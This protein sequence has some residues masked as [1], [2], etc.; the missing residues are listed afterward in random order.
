MSDK[1]MGEAFGVSDKTISRTLTA[2]EEKGFIVRDTKSTKNG[3]VRHIKAI[4][5]NIQ[6]VIATDNL[7]NK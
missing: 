7:S 4:M 5:G 6:K 2:L 3:K 1:A